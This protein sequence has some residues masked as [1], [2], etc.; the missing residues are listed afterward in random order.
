MGK[1]VL[2][3]VS[4]ALAQTLLDRHHRLCRANQ[5]AS[6]EVTEQVARVCSITYSDLIHEAGVGIIPQGIGRPLAQVAR[7]VCQPRLASA[8]RLG[9]KRGNRHPW[10]DV[11]GI[12]WHDRELA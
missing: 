6:G 1:P 12:A 9:R 8:S 5:I 2:D 7:L 10:R 3:G 11:L 4:K